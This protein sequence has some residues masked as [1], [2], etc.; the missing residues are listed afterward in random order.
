MSL[1]IKMI[2]TAKGEVA[3]LLEYNLSCSVMMVE[4]SSYKEPV[5]DDEFAH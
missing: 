2:R 1:Y 5:P 4:C 3:A